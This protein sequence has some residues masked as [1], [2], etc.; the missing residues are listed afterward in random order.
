M[1][2]VDAGWHLAGRAKRESGSEQTTRE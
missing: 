1:R 2:V